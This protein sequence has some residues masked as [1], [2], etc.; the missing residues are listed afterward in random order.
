MRVGHS[1]EKALMEPDG[2]FTVVQLWGLLIR[3]NYP[4]LDVSFFHVRICRLSYGSYTRN[5]NNQSAYI[6]LNMACPVHKYIENGQLNI[7]QEKNLLKEQSCLERCSEQGLKKLQDMAVS[8]KNS[9]SW[10]PVECSLE[11][12]KAEILS[13]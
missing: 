3:N 13:E 12:W 9:L 8:V 10:S 7:S 6:Y 11:A 1:T 4:A 5:A 2:L